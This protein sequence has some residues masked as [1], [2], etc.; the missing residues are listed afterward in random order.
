[1]HCTCS[2]VICSEKSCNNNMWSNE[3]GLTE[4]F[5]SSSIINPLVMVTL[6]R[7]PSVMG[8]TA[9]EKL[10][11]KISLICCTSQPHL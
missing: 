2:H 4:C 1:M 3:F 5:P 7:N 11:G 6:L 10:V 9:K 8:N